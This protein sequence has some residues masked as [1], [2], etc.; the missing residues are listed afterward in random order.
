VLDDL[1]AAVDL[2]R[3]GLTRS[4]SLHLDDAASRR[5]LIVLAR[6]LDPD[7]LGGGSLAATVVIAQVQST[8]VDLIAAHGLPREYARALLPRRS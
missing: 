1:A 2:I 7:E 4:P 3:G 6:R 8:V 5:E